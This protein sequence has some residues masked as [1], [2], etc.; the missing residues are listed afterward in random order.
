METIDP[1]ELALWKARAGYYK[2]IIER[3][4]EAIDAGERKTI[5]ELKALVDQKDAAVLKL[6]AEALAKIGHAD[7][8]S[9]ER[10]FLPYAEASFSYVKSLSRIDS[11]IE[12]SFWMRPEEIVGLGAADA[13]D[14]AILLC[15]L[16]LAC[17]C[18]TARVLVLELEGGGRHP[19]VV[20]YYKEKQHFLDPSQ[21]AE[22]STYSGT[23]EEIFRHYSY[24]GKKV[25]KAAFEFNHADYNEFE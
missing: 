16:L 1:Q 11:E 7:D 3:Y 23:L 5:P 10:D 17:E 12:P 8:Y 19:V 15:S 24:E 9:F 21:E 25:L 6:K 20:F 13:F 4:G 18:E 14:R 2:K 22:F